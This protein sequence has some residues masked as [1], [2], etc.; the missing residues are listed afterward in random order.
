[1][2]GSKYINRRKG[3]TLDIRRVSASTPRSYVCRYCMIVPPQNAMQSLTMP[4]SVLKGL[5]PRTLQFASNIW[6]I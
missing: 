4:F 1:M 3:R 5:G 6:K 2:I